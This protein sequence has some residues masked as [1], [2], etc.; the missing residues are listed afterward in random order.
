MNPPSDLLFIR[1]DEDGDPIGAPVQITHTSGEW[2]YDPAAAWNGAEFGFTWISQI[3]STYRVYFQRMQPDGQL[4]GS[5]LQIWENATSPALAPDILWDTDHWVIAWMDTQAVGNEVILLQL[6]D[7]DGTLMG[8]SHQIS[9]DY[10]PVD[11]MNDEIPKVHLKP[12]GGAVIYTQSMRLEA[13]ANGERVDPKTLVSP[14]DSI[15][16]TMLFNA[17]SDGTTFL[18]GWEEYFAS[19]DAYEIA[20]AIVDADGTP[21]TLNQVTSGHNGWFTSS[22]PVALPLG[23]G[24]FAALWNEG[25]STQPAAPRQGL[26][27]R[28]LLRPAQ[29]GPQP[30]RSVTHSMDRSPLR[31]AMQQP[32]I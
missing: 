11:P 21:G 8:S 15:D 10:G 5:P 31:G 24:N 25:G 16:S 27:S 22:L 14:D 12:G 7:E 6:V 4:I 28:D 20:N 9:P 23:E 30:F 29:P 1:L 3:N 32:V 13:N 17:A 18:V 2:D 26:H 19:G